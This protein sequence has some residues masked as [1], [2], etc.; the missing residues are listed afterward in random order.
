MTDAHL[1]PSSGS[2]HAD[3]VISSRARIARN[4]SGLPFVNT[5]DTQQC[6]QVT[7]TARHLLLHVPLDD[8]MIWVDLDQSSSHE[9]QLLVERHLIS[10]HHADSKVP[11][12]VAVAEN[13]M[14]SVMVNEEDHIRMQSIRPGLQLEEACGVVRRIDEALNAH[15][16]VQL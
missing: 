13:E 1:P 4:L 3:V 10:R 14:A 12:G 2:G 5:A 9:R 8:R 11:R 6:E 15:V 16:V 7:Q